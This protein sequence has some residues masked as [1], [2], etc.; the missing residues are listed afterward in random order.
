MRFAPLGGHL[1]VDLGNRAGES[2]DVAHSRAARPSNRTGATYFAG[3]RGRSTASTTTS[4]RQQGPMWVADLNPAREGRAR[5][6]RVWRTA[7]VSWPVIRVTCNSPYKTFLQ[8]GIHTA[9]CLC[10]EY[11]GSLTDT[12]KALHSTAWGWSAV[13]GPTPGMFQHQ[14]TTLKVLH[15]VRPTMTSGS[16]WNE[17]S[18]TRRCQS[19]SPLARGDRPGTSRGQGEQE[20]RRSVGELPYFLNE[21]GAQSEGIM[22]F[23]AE[24]RQT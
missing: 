10:Y 7:D 24:L 13:C 17:P 16:S 4:S 3:T 15:S 19:F 5:E 14:F 18:A 22:G 23:L 12:L 9:L 21:S 20:C 11:R 2:R 8:R 1:V 6:R